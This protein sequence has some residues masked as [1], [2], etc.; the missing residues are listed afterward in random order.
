MVSEGGLAG[1]GR[2]SDGRSVHMS[3]ET[4]PNFAVRAFSSLYLCVQDV[5]AWD[6]CVGAV[7]E[8]PCSAVLD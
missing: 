8:V 3:R 7:R 1:K 2:V 4:Q 5:A 6:G